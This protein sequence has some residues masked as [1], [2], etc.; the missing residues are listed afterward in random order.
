MSVPIFSFVYIGI[1]VFIYFRS[2]NLKTLYVDN[3]ALLFF[4]EIVYSQGYFLQIGDKEYTLII[5]QSYVVLILS[6]MSFTFSDTKG[7]KKLFNAFVIFLSIIFIGMMYQALFPYDGYIL[8]GKLFGEDCSWDLYVMGKS[9]L[10]QYAFDFLENFNTYRRIC[11][12]AF[13]I[14]IM[15]SHLNLMDISS[16][17]NK[18]LKGSI[19]VVLYGYMEMLA[20][21]FLNMPMEAYKLNEFL[22]GVSRSTFTWENATVTADGV[23]RLQGFTR[24]PSHYVL[25]LFIFGILILIAIR[26]RKCVNMSIPRWY[27]INLS[28]I[29]FLMPMTGGMSSI[30]YMFSLLVS[31]VIINLERPVNFYKIFRFIFMLLFGIGVFLFILNILAENSELALF[32]RFSSSLDTIDFVISNPSTLRLAGMDISTLARFTSVV[33]CLGNWLDNPL[34]GLGHGITGAHDFTATM[35]VGSGIFGC[36]A[37]YFFLTTSG[38]ERKKYDHLLLLVLF[39]IEFLPI[40][41]AIGWYTYFYFF[42]LTEA[43]A[44]YCKV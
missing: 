23:Y 19:L 36:A 37:W 39:C 21:N 7:P 14:Y 12:Y 9:V 38:C 18:L 4:F 3:I 27:Y 28:L 35:L 26:Y 6:I 15:K 10:Y 43:T 11:V 30:W 20:K 1:L 34:L 41:P 16:I 25:S 13:I 8:P 22:F 40:G 32:S 17:I 24:E 33:I 2:P 29:C 42:L 31:Y 5:I 44:L